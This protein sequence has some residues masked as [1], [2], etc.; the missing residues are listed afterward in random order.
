MKLLA[1]LSTGSTSAGTQSTVLVLCVIKLLSTSLLSW[2]FRNKV[3]NI[4]VPETEGFGWLFY[5]WLPGAFSCWRNPSIVQLSLK[6]DLGSTEPGCLL[7]HVQSS[8]SVIRMELVPKTP[9]GS[10]FSQLLR[11]GHCISLEISLL[12]DIYRWPLL[13]LNGFRSQQKRFWD[14]CYLFHVWFCWGLIY[15]QL[16]FDRAHG[17]E[18]ITL[19]GFSWVL[20]N[21]VIWLAP[22]LS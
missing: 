15:L 3:R 14:L 18:T 12:L 21:P 22:T 5:L 10:Q 13:W 20:L 2:V 11:L 17:Y 9:I 4:V 1:K 8:C 6:R 16:D 19:S 7:F